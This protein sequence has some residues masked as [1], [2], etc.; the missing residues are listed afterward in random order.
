MKLKM[1]VSH[2]FTL[3]EMVIV[4]AIMA[5]ILVAS[6]PSSGGKVDQV[7]INETLNLV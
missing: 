6:I 3:I 7:G 2:G 5:V 4:L 1:R